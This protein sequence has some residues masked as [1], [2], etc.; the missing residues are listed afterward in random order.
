MKRMMLLALVL[1]L[2]TALPSIGH[3]QSILQGLIDES[4]QPNESPDSTPPQ[5][6]GVPPG[7]EAT[8]PDDEDAP[9]EEA[10]GGNT[11]YELSSNESATMRGYC[12]DEYQIAPRKVTKFN[13]VLAGEGEATVTLGDGRRMSLG[14]AVKNRMVDVTAYQLQ[15]RLTNKT[16]GPMRI[17]ISKPLVFWDRPGGEVNQRALAVLASNRGDYD[18]NQNEIWRN[19]TGERLMAVLGYYDGSWWNIDGDRF[20]AA[21]ERF[22]RENGLAANGDLDDATTARLARFGAALQGRLNT[23]G[24]RDREG[25]SL[26]PD[27]AAQIRSYE[28]FAG[29]QPT[30]RWNASLATRFAGDEVIS[31][32]VRGL[33]PKSGPIAEVLAKGNVPNVVTYLNG[34]KSFLTLVET[35]N[36]LEL[37]ARNGAAQAVVGHNEGAIVALDDASAA[38]AARASSGDRIVIY[39]RVGTAT[40]TTMLSVGK[41]SVEVETKAL[42]AYLNGG[43]P[44]QAL[45]DA[46]APAMPK[47]AIGSMTGGR[48]SSATLVVYRGPFVQGRGG[49]N[50]TGALAK[51]NL[52]QVDG[53]QLAKAL[54][55]TYGDRAAVYVS[56]DLRVG[57]DRFTSGMGSLFLE[58]KGS[59]ALR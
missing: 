5:R 55:R 8:Q 33:N 1:I 43:A 49:D 11:Q 32:Q 23:L 18:D 13:H 37:W 22:Q 45:A 24:F 7:D 10:S 9:K 59:L 39:P 40:G 3:G 12:F 57:A 54:D 28:R 31:R 25:R 30:G 6:I 36:G 20:R 50:N 4:D 41:R 51:L 26:K 46:L 58:Q 38:M 48:T 34:L 15:V 56:N 16:T 14:E 17:E 2:W 21:T 19:T 47:G 27:L 44:P 35:P 52:E 29:L 42:H 53:T